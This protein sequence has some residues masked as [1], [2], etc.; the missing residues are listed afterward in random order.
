MPHFQVLNKH[1][2]TFPILFPIATLSASAL[3]HSENPFAR[4][5]HLICRF[6]FCWNSLYR[7]MENA[8]AGRCSHQLWLVFLIL[9]VLC[10]VLFHFDYSTMMPADNELPF[11]L[12]PINPVAVSENQT[13]LATNQSVTDESVGEE[14]DADTC[15]GRYVYVHNLPSRFNYGL[16][17]NCQSLTRGTNSNMCPYL[18]N[19]GLGTEIENSQGVL[20]NQSWFSTNQ[21]SLEVIFHNKMKRYE[22]LTNDSSLASAIFVPYY[23]GLDIS[24]YLWSPNIS[25]RDSP[26]KDL[27]NWLV[28]RPE[29]KKMWGRDHFLVAGRISW[30]FRRQT[31]DASDWGTKFRFLPESQNMT[32][33][34][35]ESSSWK[36]DFAIPYPTNFH[37]F[38]DSQ[39]IEWQSSVRT[40]DRSYLF[41]FAGAPRPDLSNSVRGVVIEQ[42]RSSKACKFINCSS[43]GNECDNPVNLMK[44]FRRSVYCLQ[45]PG[46]SYTRRSIFDS[47][48]A[49][50]I[51]VF[52]HPGTAYAQ[53]LWHLPGNGTEYSVYI[54]VK[55]VKNWNGSVEKIL[56]GISK[57]KELA[58]RE[59]VIGLIPNIIYSDPRSRL[60]SFEDAFDLA[61]NGV[62]ERIERV[63]CVIREG[64]DPSIGFAEGDDYK[65]TFSEWQGYEK[66]PLF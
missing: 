33:M 57:D 2:T 66:D 25:V 5:W 27:L 23:A 14:S 34:S 47:I 13:H 6:L 10:F 49:G 53:Y 56:L 19:L 60:E 39:V 16:L 45:P 24:Q 65:Y 43:E 32:M 48:L 30:D 20:S 41:T 11:S 17:K 42:C 55:D 26:G 37:P 36:N 61:V 64:K 21:F 28:E 46:D 38:K 58:M 22:C 7:R 1:T 8:I 59:E 29:W 54:P 50:C 51:P 15:L 35:V 9:F 31:D 3:L 44:V 12:D 63:R 52:F 40:Q 4:E 62:L 18:A